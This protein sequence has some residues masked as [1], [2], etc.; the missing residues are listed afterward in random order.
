M[1]YRGT[2]MGYVATTRRHVI[3]Y[4]DGDQEKLNLDEA[5]HRWLED[6]PVRAGG[7]KQG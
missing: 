3:M 1:Y 5:A 7:A 2:V 6:E 4:D